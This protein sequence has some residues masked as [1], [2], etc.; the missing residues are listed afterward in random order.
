MRIFLLVTFCLRKNNMS[1]FIHKIE[2]HVTV[3]SDMSYPYVF[4]WINLKNTVSKTAFK[5]KHGI[6]FIY[7]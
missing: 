4:T 1:V 6:L 7:F 5:N 3:K 2:F